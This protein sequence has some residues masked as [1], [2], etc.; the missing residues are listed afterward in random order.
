MPQPTIHPSFNSLSELLVSGIMTQY[1]TDDRE[2]SL[3]RGVH[4]HLGD[5]SYI[6]T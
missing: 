1:H 3:L 6:L 5:D 4:N 2:S